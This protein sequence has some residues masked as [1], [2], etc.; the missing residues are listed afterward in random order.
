MS[1]TKNITSAK[2]KVTQIKSSIGHKYDQKQTLLGLGLNKM[3]RAVILEN[4]NSTQGMLKKVK[5]LLKIENI[6]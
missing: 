6:N 1:N 2:V 3:N 5:H 4:T